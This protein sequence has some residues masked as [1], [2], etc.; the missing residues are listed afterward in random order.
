MKK[1]NNEKGCNNDF[2]PSAIRYLLI[3]F[4][5]AFLLVSCHIQPKLRTAVY[6]VNNELDMSSAHLLAF[7]ESH[8]LTM[9]ANLQWSG[10][11]TIHCI[12]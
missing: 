3:L 11:V 8:S 2:T 12:T 1:T 10:V 7:R 6:T 9:M 4:A 5:F